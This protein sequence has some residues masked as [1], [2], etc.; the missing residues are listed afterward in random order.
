MKKFHELRNERNA[1][2]SLRLFLFLC[3]PPSVVSTWRLYELVMC[4]RHERQL[5][6]LQR[7][8]SWCCNKK[9]SSFIGYVF[10]ILRKKQY[11]GYANEC[12]KGYVYCLHS[13]VDNQSS[14][15]PPPPTHLIIGNTR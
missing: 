6:G 14:S 8:E 15:L 11:G 9:I 10:E 7:I 5:T 4:K 3:S 1:S 13:D 2:E 12:L